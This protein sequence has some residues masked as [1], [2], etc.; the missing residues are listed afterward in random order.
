EVSK[1]EAFDFPQ[2]FHGAKRPRHTRNGAR[3][4]SA[5]VCG[6]PAAADPDFARLP[7]I[8]CPRLFSAAA[9]GSADTAALRQ[10]LPG[11]TGFVFFGAFAWPSK[12]RPASHCRKAGSGDTSG[13]GKFF[14]T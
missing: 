4:R 12:P 11:E 2:S 8:S 9:A 10:R 3:W 6:A 7:I 1:Y 13:R 14:G 5:A